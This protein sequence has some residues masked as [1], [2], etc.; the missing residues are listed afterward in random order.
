VTPPSNLG[1]TYNTL[2]GAATRVEAD[3]NAI[4]AAAA[5]HRSSAAKQASATLVT[6]IL[7]AK[8]SATTI[9]DKLGA[10]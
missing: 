2:T 10:Q 1:V 8:A 4:V 9:T 6:D 3:L 7:A 5:T